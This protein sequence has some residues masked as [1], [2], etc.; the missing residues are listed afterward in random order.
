MPDF[1]KVLYT[2]IEY[3]IHYAQ[4]FIKILK[5]ISKDDQFKGVLNRLSTYLNDVQIDL[6][7]LY[8]ESYSFSRNLNDLLAL[9]RKFDVKIVTRDSVLR[10]DNKY[11]Q[12]QHAVTFSAEFVKAFYNHFQNIG[13]MKDNVQR[14]DILFDKKNYLDTYIDSLNKEK[15]NSA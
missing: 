10:L 3:E 7:T 12:G 15:S 5:G 11:I 4:N 8:D 6:K 2:D 13:S 14:P 9:M 1:C